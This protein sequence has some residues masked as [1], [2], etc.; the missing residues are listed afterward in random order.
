MA[1]AIGV[2]HKLDLL[3]MEKAFKIMKESDF[4][5]F[6][7]VN[8]SP[9]SLIL[10]EFIKNVKDIILKYNINPDRIVFELTERETIKNITLLEKFVTNLKYEG[11]RFAVDDFGSGF[12]SFLYIKHFPVDFIKI[13]GEFIRSIMTDKIDRAFVISSVSI[14]KEVGIKTIAEFIENDEILQEVTKLGV[15]YG[16]GFFLAK[17]APELKS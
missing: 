2:A 14:A 4:D 6:L 15:D 3:L 12:S 7:F 11:F 5:G 10:S 16:Q 13:D 1:E 8:L 17:P 9:K